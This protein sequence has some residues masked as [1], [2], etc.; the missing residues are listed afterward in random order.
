MTNSPLLPITL[1]LLALTACSGGSSSQTDTDGDGVADSIDN[2]PTTQNADQLDTDSDGAGNACDSDDDNDG[3]P[4]SQDAFPLDAGESVDTDGDGIGNNA[5]PDDDNDTILDVDDI[6]DD[7]DNLIEIATLEQLDWMRNNLLGTELQAKNGTVYN[8]GCLSTCNGYELVAD[9]D[10]DT[11]ADGVMNSQDTYYDYDGDAQNNGWLPVGTSSAPFQAIFEGNNHSIHNLYIKRD[12]GDTETS[13]GTDIGLFGYVGN[14]EIRNLVLD[15]DLMS[16][17]GYK[18][19]GALAG[20]ANNSSISNCHAT[21]AVAGQDQTG[22][23]LGYGISSSITDSS[24]DVSVTGSLNNG[25]LAAY[26]FTCNVTNSKASGP[27]SGRGRN[28]GGLIGKASGNSSIS[29]CSASGSVTVLYGDGNTGGLLGHILKGSTISDSYATG[30]IKGRNYTGGLVG[31]VNFNLDDTVNPYTPNVSIDTSFS[32]G[33]VTTNNNDYVGGLIGLSYN[34]DLNDCFTTDTLTNTNNWVGGLIGDANQ[35][36]TV[37]H[38]FA[39]NEVTGNTGVGALVGLSDSVTYDSNYFNIDQVN[40][41]ALGSSVGGGSLNPTGTSGDSLI[42]LQ[43]VTSPGANN[44][45]INWDEAVWDFGNS[46][47]LPGLKIDGTVYRDS[48]A[49]GM[50]D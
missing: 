29:H 49:N 37:S 24:A 50:L 22:G 15:G 11:N 41:N 33:T 14:S 12:A 21:G 13:Y 40:N 4:D 46:S 3:V 9:L 8:Q 32:T 5:D 6:D 34:L 38:C 39:F 28:S 18:D 19:S 27:V 25:G 35:G 36:T 31:N 2:C 26:L 47:Q 45:F 42:N 16:V 44:L 30:A 1:L 17:E 43:G 10:F 23:L 48:D 7:N 20:Y